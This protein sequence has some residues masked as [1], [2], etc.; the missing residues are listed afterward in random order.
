MDPIY[1]PLTNEK[2]AELNNK[3]YKEWEYMSPA[4]WADPESASCKLI[5][6]YYQ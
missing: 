3:G 6:Y 1:K 2:K 5:F 4:N